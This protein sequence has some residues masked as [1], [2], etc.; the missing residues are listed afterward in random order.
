M[1]AKS[2]KYFSSMH[3]NIGLLLIRQNSQSQEKP[4]KKQEQGFSQ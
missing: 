3:K 4:L 1:I 2:Y